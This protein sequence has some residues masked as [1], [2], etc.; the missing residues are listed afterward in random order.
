M[1]Y[2]DS[3]SAARAGNQP[4]ASILTACISGKVTASEISRMTWYFESPDEQ[5]MVALNLG[6]S[7]RLLFNRGQTGNSVQLRAEYCQL[8]VGKVRNERGARIPK[9]SKHKADQEIPI[10]PATAKHIP[11]VYEASSSMEASDASD[12]YVTIEHIQ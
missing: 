1:N 5:D 7:R 12:W 2:H 4:I 10:Q 8:E 6:P 9:F 11:L 3:E